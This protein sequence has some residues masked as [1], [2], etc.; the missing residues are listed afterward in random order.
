[1]GSE[2][3]GKRCPHALRTS[4]DKH[5]TRELIVEELRGFTVAS[6]G[7]CSAP[8]RRSRGRRLLGDFPRFVK[9][10]YEGTSKGIRRELAGWRDACGA[11]RER[12]SGS[13]T[14]TIDQAGPGGEFPA[15]S[16]VH[17]DARSGTIPL[18]RSAGPA[19]GPRG[20]S[21]RDRASRR[22]GRRG[23]SANSPHYDLPGEPCRPSSRRIPR[24]PERSCAFR[25][26]RVCSG[27][28]A[29]RF[30]TRR[31][32]LTSSSSRSIPLPTFAPDGILRCPRRTRGT[33]SS[34]APEPTSGGRSHPPA[35][36][37]LVTRACDMKALYPDVPR[38]EDVSEADW[39]DWGRHCRNR[40]RNAEATRPLRRQPATTRSQRDRSLGR[41]FPLRH[42]ALLRIVDGSS[43]IPSVRCGR[44]VV[45]AHRGAPRSLA[46]QADPLDEVAHSPGEERD[47]RL[48]RIG[49]PSA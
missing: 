27:F 34:R 6:A 36:F 47:P 30:P 48:S 25:R 23:R 37:D 13:C 18:A 32:G 43:R 11:A 4:L 20:P 17:R 5:W 15:R 9:P 45:P 14:G 26:T 39:G 28:R 12:S 31:A 42:H 19:A 35:G 44:Q 49:S 33:R 16:G 10:R 46:G 41:A 24:R 40:V 22:R 21:L 3:P 38:P 8:R 2:L 29:R 1:M 7:E